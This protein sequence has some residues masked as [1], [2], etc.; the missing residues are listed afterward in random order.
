VGEKKMIRRVVWLLLGVL[1]VLAGVATAGTVPRL[2]NYQGR[3]T[4][5]DGTPVTDSTYSV[6][7]RFFNAATGGVLLWQETQSVTTAKGIFSVLLGSIDSLPAY[8]FGGDSC[9]LELEPQGSAPLT[10]R[11]NIATVPYA[12]RAQS[13]DLLS[14]LPASDFAT[15]GYV[16]GTMG[17][18]LAAPDPHNSKTINAGDL[19]IGTLD[20]ARLPK[21]AIDSS[22][23]V[24]ASLTAKQILDAPGISHTF[25]SLLTIPSTMRI[26]D[27]AYVIVPTW[28]YVLVLA[29]GWFY[30]NHVA[31]ADVHATI[32]ISASRI[33]HDNSY[34][35]QF[36]VR[37]AAPIGNT[38]EDF[39]IQR[40][41]T[42]GP[43]P[44]KFFVLGNMVGT[45][46]SN[47]QN[48]HVNTIFFPKSYGEIDAMTR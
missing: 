27:S 14:G 44:V 40:V 29:S 4:G 22:N 25:N 11:S 16:D 45:E 35:A 1:L 37:P 43:G 13:A 8:V 38:S 41:L 21:H 12:F 24:D 32:S 10:P 15:P 33:N 19:I 17:N 42:V 30:V 18:H 34:T 26:L 3:L 23:I 36:D 28:G 47:V 20:K 31:T 39:V 5:L 9:Y 7:F 48:L 46:L 6:T 2:V